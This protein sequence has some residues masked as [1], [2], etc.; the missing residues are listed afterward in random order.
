MPIWPSPAATATVFSE[1]THIRSGKRSISTGKPSGRIDRSETALMQCR[2]APVRH[3]VDPVG[4]LMKLEIGDRA[5]RTAN[6]VAI[7]PADKTHQS[8]GVGEDC[9]DIDPFRDQLW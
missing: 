2:D 1:T 9:L 7:Q 4:R 6:R 8:F 3:F 5:R